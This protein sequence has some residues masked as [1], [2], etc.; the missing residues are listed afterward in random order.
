MLLELISPSINAKFNVL[1]I[2]VLEYPRR[3][4]T[5]IPLKLHY[6]VA[7]RRDSN[8]DTSVQSDEPVYLLPQ[9]IVPSTG[10]HV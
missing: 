6:T 3:T 9:N 8:V 10:Y 4:V 7:F 1:S 5:K 2:G